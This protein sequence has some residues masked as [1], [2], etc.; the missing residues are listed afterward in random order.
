MTITG[1]NGRAPTPFSSLHEAPA[2]E[3]R[4]LSVVPD[5]EANTMAAC[6]I[7]GHMPWLP[8][9]DNAFGDE[10]EQLRK[11]REMPRR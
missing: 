3:R 1:G 5:N 10:A 8:S 2:P 11:L 9:T 4:E 6:T 7:A